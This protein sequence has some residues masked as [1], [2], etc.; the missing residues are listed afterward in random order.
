MS[1]TSLRSPSAQT[2]LHGPCRRGPAS[3]LPC[4]TRRR[5][6]SPPPSDRSVLPASRR[7]CTLPPSPASAPPPS[8]VSAPLRT[9]Q[10]ALPATCFA[11]MPSAP[12]AMTTTQSPLPVTDCAPAVSPLRFGI[13][14]AAR[15]ASLVVGT[16]QPRI[17]HL[18]RFNAV[19]LIALASPA[20]PPRHGPCRRGPASRL[21]CATR[22]HGP[23]P[24][25]RTGPLFQLRTASTGTVDTDFPHHVLLRCPRLRH[26]APHACRQFLQH[27]RAFR[28]AT[29]V[30]TR[31]RTTSCTR[32]RTTADASAVASGSVLRT[33]ALS[34]SALTAHSVAVAAP[35]RR[36]PPAPIP[37]SLEPL[38][39]SFLTACAGSGSHTPT[40]RA[41]GCAPRAPMDRRLPAQPTPSD[42]RLLLDRAYVAPIHD[43]LPAP[44]HA[45]LRLSCT[46]TRTVHG[47]YTGGTRL[48][49]PQNTDRYTTDMRSPWLPRRP[50]QRLSPAHARPNAGGFAEIPALGF[51]IGRGIESVHNTRSDRIRASHNP[52]SPPLRRSGSNDRKGAVWFHARGSPAPGPDSGDEKE[53]ERDEIRPNRTRIRRCAHGKPGRC[54]PDQRH[55][56]LRFRMAR[57]QGRCRTARRPGRRVRPQEHSRR[58][59]RPTPGPPQPRSR[60]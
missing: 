9:P 17:V 1:F 46:G 11:R 60:R 10:P 38:V 15:L 44:D 31:F 58:C 13:P 3:R 18:P 48:P 20:R 24:L 47:R 43:V 29:L 19:H 30:G 41:A 14:R 5:G 56:L 53:K 33:T 42:A 32:V 27:L 35:L 34:S 6:P 51:L 55:P 26:R 8:S 50:R 2:P 36:G 22:R 16:L 21:P 54:A 23:S 39:S 40:Q 4:A 12:S 37:P 52:K 57:G 59:P 7:R 25:R 28:L 45:W 49:L